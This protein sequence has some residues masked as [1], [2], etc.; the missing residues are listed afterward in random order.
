MYN[1]GIN[2]PNRYGTSKRQKELY[3]VSSH[4]Y[5]HMYV[6][7]KVAP[8]ATSWWCLSTFRR[9]EDH[10]SITLFDIKVCQ[11]RLIINSP[12]FPT[13]GLDFFKNQNHPEIFKYVLKSLL[14]SI[15]YW[16]WSK[17][18]VFPYS[19]MVF[20]RDL[21]YWH[22][23]LWL[24]AWCMFVTMKITKLFNM[25]HMKCL[26]ECQEISSLSFLIHW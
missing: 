24:F 15:S 6:K 26:N 21:R 4:G 3:F 5:L 23:R 9:S 11:I 8:M 22:T 17:R 25:L 20:H 7:S 18:H 2:V 10:V 14:G 13:V 19:R 16:F 12:C 1:I